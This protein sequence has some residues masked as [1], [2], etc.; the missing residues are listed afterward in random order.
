[1]AFVSIR[2]VYSFLH[3]QD[4][5]QLNSF[6]LQT[7]IFNSSSI[8]KPEGSH[9]PTFRTIIHVRSSIHKRNEI[10]FF[11]HIG[12]LKRKLIIRAD[13]AM[14]KVRNRVYGSVLKQF[15][16]GY[17]TP[18]S[19]LDISIASEMNFKR[20]IVEGHHQWSESG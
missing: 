16:R 5:F 19:A 1:M 17:S 2:P 15:P 9:S 8:F 7:Q 12:I 4:F 6:S 3:F 10:R 14:P 20:Y 18:F 13:N 11:L